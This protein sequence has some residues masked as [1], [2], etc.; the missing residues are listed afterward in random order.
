MSMGHARTITVFEYQHLVAGPGMADA[1]GVPVEV[2]NWLE[3]ECLRMSEADDAAWAKPRFRNGRRS[4]QMTNSVGVIRTPDGFQIEV[5][6]KIGKIARDKGASSRVL[7]LDMLACLRVFR[8]IRMERAVLAA[9]R[10]PLFE[11]FIA[12]FLESVRLALQRGL[13]SHYNPLEDN[14]AALRGKLLVSE[15]LKQNLVRPDRFFVAFDEFTQNRPEN[16]LLH[17][18]LVVA[19]GQTQSPVN[20]RLARELKFAFVDIPVSADTDRDFGRVSRQR[21]MDHY[22]EPLAWARLLLTGH[23]PVT[24]AG[25]N[26]APSL[27]FPMDALFEAFVSKHLRKQLAPDHQLKVQHGARHLLE[28][29][30]KRMFRMRPDLLVTRS[31]VNVL[32]ADTKWKLINANA[33]PGAKYWLSQADLYQ[34]HAY[35]HSFM[36]A[37]GDVILIFPETDDFCAPLAP[38]L[39]PDRPELIL[40]VLPF[41]LRTKRIVLPNADDAR[42]GRMLNAFGLAVAPAKMTDLRD[43]ATANSRSLNDCSDL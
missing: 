10:M 7:L 9:R 40:W 14:L 27:L 22:E 29:A 36:D 1:A 5:L 3:R 42:N 37:K 33:E 26:K 15:T 20:Q 34:M 18:A 11:V 2:F 17:S 35:G 25:A 16:R 23:S 39:F 28:H 43:K 12:E 41:S 31:K 19:L 38:F 30:G 8:H 21:G 24:G 32:V 13:R 6:P 4:I